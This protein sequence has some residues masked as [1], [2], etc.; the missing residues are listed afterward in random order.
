MSPENQQ[1]IE[2]SVKNILKAVGDDPDRSGL[3]ET[4][5]RVAKMYAEV[6]SSLEEPNFDDIKIF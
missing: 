5:A 4:P 3:K 6:F 2:Q 1:I